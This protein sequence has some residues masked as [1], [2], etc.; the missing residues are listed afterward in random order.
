MNL[1]E[2]GGKKTS[3]KKKNKKATNKQTHGEEDM[4]GRYK[5]M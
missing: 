3:K 4:I 2:E 5:A 1:Q